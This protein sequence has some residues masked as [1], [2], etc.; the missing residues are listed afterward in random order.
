MNWRKT[1][2]NGTPSGELTPSHSYFGGALDK[3]MLALKLDQLYAAKT[4]DEVYAAVQSVIHAFR[5]NGYLNR[6]PNRYGCLCG[7]SREA[8]ELWYEHLKYDAEA[9]P[10][11]RLTEL[12]DLFKTAM[13][14]LRIME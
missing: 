5:S 1:T 11:I 4:P 6:L 3:L 14:M 9:E 10:N 8:I 7:A 12:R 2:L 13:I